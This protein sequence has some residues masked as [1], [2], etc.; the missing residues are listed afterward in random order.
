VP[1]KKKRINY[2]PFGLKHK[3]YNN[4]VSSNGN[5]TAQKFGFGG[6]ELQDDNI[7]GTQL[8]WHD[9]GA[10]NYDASLGRW[11][12]LDPL[13][14]QMR[15]HS[16]YNYAFNNPIYFI[17][18]DGMAPQDWFENEKGDIV[19]H[20]SKAKNISNE[21]GSWE[22]IGENLQDVKEHLNLPSDKNFSETDVSIV[23]HGRQKGVPAPVLTDVNVNVSTD[24]TLDNA[25]ELGNDRIDGVTSV[26]SVDINTTVTATTNASNIGLGID[27]MGGKT[28]A[29]SKWTP[30]GK[31]PSV[32]ADIVNKEGVSFKPAFSTSAT[33]TSSMKIGLKKYNRLTRNHSVTPSSISVKT[34][35]SVKHG[36][37][38]KVLT[39]NHTVHLKK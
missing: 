34:N 15:R 28:S 29:F 18:P 22:N 35:I 13:A 9:F 20:D 23:A 25:G 38:K 2:Y 10:R 4:V 31:S 5:S 39:T 32:S 8:N 7:G 14:E 16:P 30:T 27:K 11:M 3:G 6:K 17:D 33:G 19:W 1:D 24:L 21:K 37:F 12:N 36:Q 26:S